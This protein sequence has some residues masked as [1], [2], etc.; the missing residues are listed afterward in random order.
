LTTSKLL[1][2]VSFNAFYKF[3]TRRYTNFENTDFAPRFDV[4]DAN[5]GFG[6]TAF[7]SVLNFKF[8][9]NN[10]LN[11]DYHVISG[12]PMPLRNYKFEM[13]FKY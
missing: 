8:I 6:L 7:K 3:N 4:L 9:V 2:F 10:I 11:E 1:K 5:I 13:G 12:Y